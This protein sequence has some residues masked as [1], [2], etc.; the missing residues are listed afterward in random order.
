MVS[1]CEPVSNVLVGH[2]R[3]IRGNQIFAAESRDYGQADWPEVQATQS[4]LRTE[5]C[6]LALGRRFG[7]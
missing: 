3:N 1:A 6:C 2:R 7:T 4:Q 5:V